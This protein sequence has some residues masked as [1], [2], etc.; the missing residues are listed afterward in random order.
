MPTWLQH[1]KLFSVQIF[2]KIVSRIFQIN[3]Q[4]NFTRLAVTIHLKSV[5]H[6]HKLIFRAVNKCASLCTITCEAL[7]HFCFVFQP[8][9]E[10]RSAIIQFASLATWKLLFR[11]ATK[12]IFFCSK[13]VRDSMMRDTRPRITAF[14]NWGK[15]RD[16]DFLIHF[17]VVSER[18]RKKGKHN[19]KNKTTTKQSEGVRGGCKTTKFLCE[20]KEEKRQHEESSLCCRVYCLQQQN[21]DERK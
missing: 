4:L 2:T 9:L 8:P 14:R 17:F 15:K 11:S 16:E 19:R 5:T 1:R 3:F 7:M 20:E 18:R 10:T 13:L 21:E 6:V 12:K